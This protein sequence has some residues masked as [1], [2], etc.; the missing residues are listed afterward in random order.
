MN[1]ESDLDADG[2]HTEGNLDAGGTNL[3]LNSTHRDHTWSQKSLDLVVTTQGY[4][5]DSPRE[6][7]LWIH[8]I[9][10]GIGGDNN[11]LKTPT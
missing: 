7:K 10:L 6:L 4:T 8:S 9:T 5:R 3:I 11:I 2:T 1:T